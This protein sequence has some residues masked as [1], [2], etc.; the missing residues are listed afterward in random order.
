ML[1]DG[2]QSL[3]QIILPLLKAWYS[4]REPPAELGRQLIGIARTSQGYSCRFPVLV[5]SLQLRS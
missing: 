3:S 2:H 1:L 4:M 5:L